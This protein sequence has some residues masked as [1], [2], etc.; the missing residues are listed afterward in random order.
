MVLAV[1]EKDKPLEAAT[2][3]VV[4]LSYTNT[5]DEKGKWT[6]KTGSKKELTLKATL[7]EFM[8]QEVTVK[9]IKRGQT[10]DLIIKMQK[11]PPTM[12]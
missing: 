5:S 11:V 3:E 9:K 2:I 10:T 8:P 12:V 1:D 6:V 7:T 4:E